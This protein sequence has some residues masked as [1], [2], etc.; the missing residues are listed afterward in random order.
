M[1]RQAILLIIFLAAC[2]GPSREK[3][4]GTEIQ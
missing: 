2:F 3:D 4:I 1:N